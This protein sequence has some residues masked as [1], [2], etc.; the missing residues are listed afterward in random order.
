MII[1]HDKTTVIYKTVIR[2]YDHNIEANINKTRHERS[3][4]HE[5]EFENGKG[6]ADVLLYVYDGEYAYV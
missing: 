6:D 1:T 4:E 3:D 5:K 2:G